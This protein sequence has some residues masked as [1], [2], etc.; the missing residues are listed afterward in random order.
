MFSQISLAVVSLQPASIAPATNFSASGRV[1]S[2]FLLRIAWRGGS[3]AGGEP[4]DLGEIV[5]LTGRAEIRV[6][7]PDN[8]YTPRAVRVSPGTKVS[9]VNVGAN[10]HN[11]TPND[12]GPWVPIEMRSGESSTL[13]APTGPGTDRYYCTLHGGRASGQRGALI[14]SGPPGPP[15]SPGSAGSPGPSTAG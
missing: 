8:T 12:E 10:T 3:A 15:G 14:V 9:F 11:V 5:D 7:V 6:D 2:G 13:T 1:T 4:T